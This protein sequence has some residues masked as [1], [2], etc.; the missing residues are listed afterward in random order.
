MNQKEFEEK[1]SIERI[2]TNSVKWDGLKKKFGEDNL[3]S[4]W[5]ADMDFKV[6]QEVISV[7]NK[8]I[9]H[10]V[11]GYAEIKDSYY[12]AFIKWEEEKHNYRVKKE[13]IRYSP[14]VVSA[15]YWLVNILTK[16]NDSIIISTPVYYPF[17]NAVK[18]NNRKLIIS[19]LKNNNGY[20]SFDFID[21]ERKIVEN[22]VKIY[23]LCSPHNPVGRVWKESELRTILEICKRNNV[24][25]ISDEI[26][27][28]LVLEGKHIPTA[29]IDNYK[30]EDM[31]ITLTAPSKTFNLA[32]CKNSFVI[33]TNNEIMEKFDKYT[34]TVVRVTNGNEFG[35]LAAEA[36]YTQGDRWLNG[37]KKTLKQNFDYM[38]ETLE[39]ELPLAKISPL[40]GT[41]LA[42]INMEN[43]IQ[44]DELEN[45]IQGKC[46]L[47]VDYGHWFGDAGQGCIRI[48][49]ATSK[50][51]I[52]EAMDR[53]I[54]EVKK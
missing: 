28:D 8:K 52:I 48:N 44:N 7:L 41:Y 13:N 30:Y 43:Y 17:H 49:I 9:E 32:G 45:I 19:D 11:F 40:E 16:E 38:K 50:D 29:I 18:E 2:N 14:G 12:D 10:G 15:I 21:F 46:K 42:W 37:V 3:L 1:Y 54:K 6:P 39:R 20:Y 24:I 4:M 31:V 23:I 22:N 53:I 34:S 33:I 36:A 5:V 25:V 26:H 47:A 51:N 35:Y 27:H